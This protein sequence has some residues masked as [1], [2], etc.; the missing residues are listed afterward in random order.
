MFRTSLSRAAA[1]AATI[2]VLAVIAA[3][4]SGQVEGTVKLKA[5]GGAPKTVAG[6]SVEIYR[7]DVKAHYEAIKTDKNGHFVR[8]GLPLQGSY[9]FLFSAPG[10]APTYMNNIHIAQMPVVDV[11]LDPGDGRVLT[12]DDVQKVLAE[13]KAGGG[14]GGGGAPAA[15]PPSPGDKAKA[16]AAQ[17]EYESKVAESKEVQAT[18][19]QAR[20][21]YN[22]GVELMQASNYQ[23]A[24][25]EFEQASTVDPSKHAAMALL[26]YR[27]NANMAE[28]HY[29]IGVDLFNKKQRPEAKTHFEAA[30]TGVKKALTLAV[31]DTA[32]NN[33]N[34]NND[35]VI[36]YNML[37][38]N[39]M[40][41]IEY[42]GAANLV[43]DTTKEL[44][45]AEVIDPTNKNKWEVLKAD[46]YRSAGRTDDAVAT[47]KKVLAADPAYADALYGLG[48]TLIASSERAQIQEGANTLA[49]FLAKAPATDKRLPIVKSSLE[50]L[51]NGLK[52]EAEKPA[53][54]RRGKKP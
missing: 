36:Y 41:L 49:E 13:R 33:P 21:H 42:Y 48:L 28:A 44:D 31:K 54:T 43:E 6:A 39:A 8:L 51:K 4:Q 25:T 34:L 17:K 26:A 52:I 50:E 47:Y 46:M 40:L 7:L 15:R 32:E 22:T 29:Q 18:F 20:T 30:I 9:L 14:G 3:A 16:D 12:F 11:T 23:S 2:V 24:L 10:A 37:G 1:L 35:L 19:D 53:P 27:A 38:K 45:K 5:E